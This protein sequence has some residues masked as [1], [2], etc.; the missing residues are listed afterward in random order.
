MREGGGRFGFAGGVDIFFGNPSR[1][2]AITNRAFVAGGENSLVIN[3][4]G[5]FTGGVTIGSKLTVNGTAAGTSWTNTSD[6]RFKQNISNL[7]S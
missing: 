3:Y 5:D 7:T 6:E 2:S 1:G 4:A